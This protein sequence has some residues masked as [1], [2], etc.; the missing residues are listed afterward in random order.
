LLLVAATASVTCA[1]PTDA[2]EPPTA[3][4]VS[5]EVSGPGSLIAG[6]FAL[7][8]VTARD[9]AGQV[10]TPTPAVSYW[11]SDAGIATVTNEGV[12]TARH[13]GEATITVR[14]DSASATF[15]VAVTARLIMTVVPRYIWTAWS[16]EDQVQG[17]FS[18]H[19]ARDICRV[20]FA[21]TDSLQFVVTQTD[22]N[23]N[24]IDSAP[25]SSWQSTDPSA[26]SVNSAGLAI[27]LLPNRQAVIS[28]S[29]PY[30]TA[31][32]AVTVSDVAVGEPAM[33]RF[34]HTAE[35]LGPIT[36]YTNRIPPVTLTYGQSV[37][38][39]VPSGTF[40]AITAGLP[41]GAYDAQDFYGSIRPG[42][43]LSLYGV[44]GWDQ[45]WLTSTWGRHDAIPADSGL[46]RVVQSSDFPVV[47][48]RDTGEPRAGLPQ[49][50]YFDPG[51]PSDFYQRAG[52][53]FD[54]ILQQKAAGTFFD[55][56]GASTRLPVTVPSGQAVTLVLTGR[57]IATASYFVF[58]D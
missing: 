45:G 8:N 6:Q 57:S 39:A 53:T 28:A 48:L 41:E 40:Y 43:H 56:T 31:S 55:T 2:P 25:A 22:V 33:V 35:G 38:L 36:W 7:V 14:R 1:G 29:T 13:R 46:V 49:L 17:S 23:G 50:C 15:T 58:P 5:L 34:A 30:G 11:S 32:A 52:G 21:V 54:L 4:A 20:P 16:A 51:I 47:Y 12:V 37:D 18:C 44:A 24:T 27:A 10:L 9:A 42:D 19:S 3:P 26:V